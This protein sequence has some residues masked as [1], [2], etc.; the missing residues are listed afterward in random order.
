MDPRARTPV[1]AHH[2]HDDP[3]AERTWPRRSDARGSTSAPEEIVTAVVATAAYLRAEH[4]G[5]RVFVLSDGDAR[6]DLEGVE[7]VDDPRRPT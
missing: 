7:L 4:P 2:E 5:A 1:P 6:E 3:H